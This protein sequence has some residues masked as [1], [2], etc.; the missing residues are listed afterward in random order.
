MYGDENRYEKSLHQQQE[1]RK[2]H[3]MSEQAGQQR[4]PINMP[5]TDK[6]EM[7]DDEKHLASTLLICVIVMMLNSSKDQDTEAQSNA[8]M[9]AT[10]NKYETALILKH[11]A[12]VAKAVNEARLPNAGSSV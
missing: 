3:M 11:R 1:Q 5:E 12:L 9:T 2:Q 8:R 10:L 6:L 4:L 7:T